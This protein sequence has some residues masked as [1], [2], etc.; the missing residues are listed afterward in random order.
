[1]SLVG[2][3]WE[4]VEDDSPSVA[5]LERDVEMGKRCVECLAEFTKRH[6]HPKTL[7]RP[8][9][10]LFIEQRGYLLATHRE[11]NAEGHAQRARRRRAHTERG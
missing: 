7:C 9:G 4:G 10:R 6:N 11:A 8:C 2:V 5:S 3:E 1:M